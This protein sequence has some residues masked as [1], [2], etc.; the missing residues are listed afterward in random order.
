MGGGR[1]EQS[2]TMGLT[3]TMMGAYCIMYIVRGD[4]CR[5][6]LRHTGDSA[7]DDE[8]EDIT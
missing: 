3:G 2:Y 5:V 6:E 7:G 4:Q 8:G 1:G